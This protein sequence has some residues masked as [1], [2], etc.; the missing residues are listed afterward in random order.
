M[1]FMNFSE[2]ISKADNRG[3]S[4]AEGA[5]IAGGTAGALAAGGAGRRI[6]NFAGQRARVK[7]I[8]QR[9]TSLVRPGDLARSRNLSRAG[10]IG[11]TALAAGGLGSAINSRRQVSKADGRGRSF[12]ESAAIAG[13]TAGALA[14]GGAGRRISDFAGQRARVKRIDQRPT[15]LIRPKDLAR[16]RNLSRAGVIGGTALAA[17]GLG[18]AINSRRQVSKKLNNNEKKMIRRDLGEI[19]VA[20]GG[21]ASTTAGVH[22]HHKADLRE[23]QLH[24]P[25]SGSGNTSLN[26]TK[27]SRKGVYNIAS[28]SKVNPK[29]VRNLR[30]AGNA[31]IAG[32]IGLGLG[33]LASTYTPR[34]YDY[35]DRVKKSDTNESVRPSA[36]EVGGI[37]AGSAALG[38][39]TVALLEASTKKQR[40][41]TPGSDARAFKPAKR[42]LSG[43][44]KITPGSAINP[45]KSI[46]NLRI[47]GG[48]GLAGGAGILARSI[49]S[50]SIPEPDG[51][52]GVK[53][54]DHR[55]GKSRRLSGHEVDILAAGGITAA[56]PALKNAGDKL[57]R[58]GVRLAA[59]GAVKDP[60]SA[61][62]LSKPN[63][64][65]GRY[66]EAGRVVRQM[67][68]YAPYAG[69][70]LA[71]LGVSQAMRDNRV[72]K[73]EWSDREYGARKKVQSALS[74]STGVL[75]VGALG[76]LAAGRVGGA[77]IAQQA[78]KAAVPL[79]VA[80][81]GVGGL[82]SF[83]L[84]SL[85][86]QEAKRAKQDRDKIARLQRDV[87]SVKKNDAL[88]QPKIPGP[89]AP[90]KLRPVAA[91]TITEK[92]KITHQKAVL[93][94]V[95]KSSTSEKKR[96]RRLEHYKTAV[97][98]ATGATGGL[99]GKTGVDAFKNRG[100][101]KSMPVGTVLNLSK[102]PAALAAA[103]GGLAATGVGIDRYRNNKGRTYRPLPG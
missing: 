99:A 16:S 36:K 76:S 54:S 40:L 45:K 3:R 9:P 67:G 65:A 17:G 61:F 23:R 57:T 63:P 68:K 14:A 52:D 39:G 101:V 84:A 5:A 32:G 56:S 37:A 20:A 96:N 58:E 71:G 62:G 53:K 98:I 69:A 10:V 27:Q 4:F 70:G 72:S 77:R 87:A 80:S 94:Q 81:T 29:S 6:S 47:A 49:A 8:N 41:K 59:E 95:A 28:D 21:L 15:A 34:S 73:R 66:K 92:N 91:K 86:G 85:S 26:P 75:G 48:A 25:S 7:R 2:K 102:K 35:R 1:E 50:N 89:P 100:P 55:G 93:N 38:A 12:A 24:S 82:S 22:A 103:T 43:A 64:K 83:H 18:S 51:Y 44:Y 46:R 79:S 60:K 13:G 11:G 88:K 33:A 78:K 30:R 97:D 74:T 31:A 19:G 90:A 42:S